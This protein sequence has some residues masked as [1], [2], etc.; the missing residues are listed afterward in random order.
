M[1]NIY[2]LNAESDRICEKLV[3]PIATGELNQVD[4]KDRGVNYLTGTEEVA[5]TIVQNE[6]GLF[7]SDQEDY[8]NLVKTICSLIVA[9]ADKGL[10]AWQSSTEYASVV[11]RICEEI[12]RRSDLSVNDKQEAYRRLL[13]SDS[14][15]L[16]GGQDFQER[17][18]LLQS[19]LD[20]LQESK[21]TVQEIP[22]AA[23]VGNEDDSWGP[24][25]PGQPKQTLTLAIDSEN[26][27]S[28]IRDKFEEFQAYYIKGSLA[29]KPLAHRIRADSITDELVK[30]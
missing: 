9:Q 20:R 21:T 1:E 19:E 8:R 26:W 18:S 27:T 3:A 28:E 14:L 6:R 12:F 25:W 2:L 4:Y 10:R 15:F 29:L 5:A 11:E 23:A 24:E 13:K 16:N 7:F 22:E 30:E 17:L